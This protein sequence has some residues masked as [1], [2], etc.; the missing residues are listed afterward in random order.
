MKPKVIFGSIAGVA[1]ML[2]GIGG[3]WV[4][5]NFD[6]VAAKL[7]EAGIKLAAKRGVQISPETVKLVLELSGGTAGATAAA[8]GKTAGKTGKQA[9]GKASKTG[10][11]TAGK[12]RQAG[13]GTA[14]RIPK[15][16]KSGE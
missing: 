3:T 14:R 4:I 12:A 6:T 8:A 13:S 11:K 10:Q 9:A 7:L 5:L 1:V 2:I 16:A 15:P